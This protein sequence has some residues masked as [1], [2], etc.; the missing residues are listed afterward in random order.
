MICDVVLMLVPSANTFG[1]C[2]PLPF[3]ALS[4][5]I[6]ISPR[7]DFSDPV[8]SFDPIN[9]LSHHMDDF[10]FKPELEAMLGLFWPLPAA[11]MVAALRPLVRARVNY[12]ITR[13]GV[14]QHRLLP[15]CGRRLIRLVRIL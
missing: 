7:T 8:P 13:Q 4:D 15:C 9:P 1:S 10:Y 12:L 5:R 6:S 14:S 11:E 3:H 2:L